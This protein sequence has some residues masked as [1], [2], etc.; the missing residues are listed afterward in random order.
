MQF[1]CLPFNIIWN[2]DD[3]DDDDDDDDK[4]NDK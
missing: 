3:D 2:N 1:I 4:S